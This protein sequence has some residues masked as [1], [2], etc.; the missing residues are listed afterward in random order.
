MRPLMAL[1]IACVCLLAGFA[2][3][4][5]QEA[6]KPLYKSGPTWEYR[7]V[8]LDELIADVE[9]DAAQIEAVQEKFNEFGREGWELSENLFRA[10][11][12]KRAKE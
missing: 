2:L 11:V 12:F 4:R 8:P 5:G 10:V 3:L 1:A 6:E 7:L 9:G